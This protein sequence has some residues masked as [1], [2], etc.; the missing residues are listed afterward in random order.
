M[1]K[2]IVLISVVIA[3]AS[4][5]KLTRDMKVDKASLKGSD[6]RLFQDSPAWILAKAVWDDDSTEVKKIVMS[7]TSLLNY[8]EP[9]Y[10]QTILFIP[11]YHNQQ[12][13]VELLLRL[14]GKCNIYDA[15]S[16]RSPI[17]EA[18]ENNVDTTLLHILLRHGANASDIEIGER[19]TG[20]TTRNT[21][22]IVASRNGNLDLVKMLI[23]K[24]ANINFVNEYDQSALSECVIVER[25]KVAYYLLQKGADYKRPIFYRLDYS[26]PSEQQDPKEKGMPMYLANVLREDFFDLDSEE[27]KLKMELVA[28]MKTKGIDYRAT[29]VPEYIKKKA[30]ET[31]PKTWQDYLDKY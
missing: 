3:F 12:R 5:D 29:P 24:G 27:F 8:R 18:C 16:G 10:G 25:Y 2:I 23:D 20:N 17:I 4:C 6:Y 21:P 28:F 26:I 9:I 7:D 14:G 19:K 22:L 31:Y 11:I 30:Q 13:I 1:K 15:F